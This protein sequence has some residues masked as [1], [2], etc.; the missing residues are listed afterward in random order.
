[1]YSFLKSSTH[2]EHHLYM[3]VKDRGISVFLTIVF[4]PAMVDSD[5]FL[6]RKMAV[7]FIENT[8]QSYDYGCISH[9][10]SNT[11]LTTSYRTIKTPLGIPEKICFV[12]YQY[13]PYL[14]IF[15]LVMGMKT[16]FS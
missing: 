6:R 2:N 1:M 14:R 16:I 9:L 15:N 10:M 13:P 5:R 8:S 11:F 7:V 12:A 4:I 3:L